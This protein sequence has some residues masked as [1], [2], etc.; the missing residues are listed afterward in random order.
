MVGRSGKSVEDEADSFGA[1]VPYSSL[2]SKMP[3]SKMCKCKN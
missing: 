1:R 3:V 2:A